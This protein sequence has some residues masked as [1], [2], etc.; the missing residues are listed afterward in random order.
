M[1][2]LKT[3]ALRLIWLMLSSSWARPSLRTTSCSL[4]KHL[5][6]MVTRGN[7]S[8]RLLSLVCPREQPWWYQKR[9]DLVTSTQLDLTTR[10]R[11]MQYL[12]R[13]QQCHQDALTSTRLS[14]NCPRLR[15]QAA[16][17]RLVILLTPSAHSNAKTDLKAHLLTIHNAK[18]WLS[19]LTCS[20][21]WT[22]S[23]PTTQ[24]LLMVCS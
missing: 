9:K 24:W 5:W 3:A 10:M 16:T 11:P 21:T 22:T 1:V 20:K 4:V 23:K 18:E 8:Y 14:L 19:S 6:L 7:R 17:G 12:L 13:Q 15:K 2:K